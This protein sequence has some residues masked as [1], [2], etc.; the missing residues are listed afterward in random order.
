[1]NEDRGQRVLEIEN[2]SVDYGRRSGRLVHALRNFSLSINEGEILGV[3]GESGSGKTTLALAIAHLLDDRVAS[4]EGGSINF[5]GTELIRSRPSEIERIRGTQIFMIFQDPFSSLNPLMRIRDQLIE[6]IRVRETRLGNHLD[7]QRAEKEVIDD[8]RAVR[9]GD[10]EDLA[11]RYPHQLSGGQN[12]RV[13]LAMALAERPKLLI[14]DEPTTALDVTTQAQIL[15][16]LKEIVEKTRMSVMFVTHDLA[17]AGSICNRIVVLY[18]G[19]AQEIG[20]A[21]QILNHPSHPYTIGLIKSIPSK[22]KSQ[23]LLDSIQGAFSW[24]E[25]GRICAFAPRCPDAR[26][27]CRKGVPALMKADDSL[28]RCINY[29]ME[30]DKQQ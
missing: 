29:G 2:L 23:G 1:L 14:A 8:L 15:N 12:Q 22:T 30:Y 7:K 19:M 16:L 5:L 6:A 25:F 28:V 3:V 24:E 27:G 13:M 26:E 10:A 9:I 20:P 17:V 18:G 4:Y 11:S 21:Q